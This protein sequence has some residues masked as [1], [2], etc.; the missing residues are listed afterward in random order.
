MTTG[1]SEQGH[2][3]PHHVWN[4][5]YGNGD[6]NQEEHDHILDCDSCFELLLLCLKSD[7]FGTV[8][9]ALL[10]HCIDPMAFKKR[11][12]YRPDPLDRASR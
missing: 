8:L 2:I 9:R 3:I 6:I 11:T 12:E 5:L 10:D 1:V 4:F 7:T